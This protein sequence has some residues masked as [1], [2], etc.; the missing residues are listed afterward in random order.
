MYEQSQGA[1]AVSFNSFSLVLL[2]VLLDPQ[3]CYDTIVVLIKKIK[4][5]K[6]TNVNFCLIDR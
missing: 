5:K 4:K 2:A 3:H 1:E 6:K